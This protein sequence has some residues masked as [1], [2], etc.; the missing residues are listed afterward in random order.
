[1]LL[2]T[3]IS[4]DLQEENISAVLSKDETLEIEACL[5]VS[6]KQNYL[7]SEAQKKLNTCII[8]HE[9]IFLFFSFFP[10][11]LFAFES[12]NLKHTMTWTPQEIMNTATNRW[13]TTNNKSYPINMR[14][15]KQHV[16]NSIMICNQKLYFKKYH[17]KLSESK[18]YL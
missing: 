6:Q 7:L 8:H 12:L 17:K 5:P 16:S 1:M 4:D 11:F 3:L 14:A 13:S 18:Y 15:N 2:K 9:S 10:F